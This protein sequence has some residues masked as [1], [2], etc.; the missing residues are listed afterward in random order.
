VK[1]SRFLPIL[2]L[3]ACAPT[4]PAAA[5]AARIPTAEE[6][7]R[8]LTAVCHQL[9]DSFHPFFGTAQVGE[10]EKR[11]AEAEGTE[12]APRLMRELARTHLRLGRPD[13][14]I[15]IYNQAA[16]LA[17]EGEMDVRFQLGLIADLGVA[18]LRWGTAGS[19]ATRDA[20]GQD[21]CGP[22][23]RRAQP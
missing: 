18:F 11:L 5:A 22:G 13:R 21:R 12:E 10:Y 7:R 19:A 15:E 8:E 4:A 9:R 14:A 2:L 6:T 20:S 16:R 3:A 1:R 17:A 23:L